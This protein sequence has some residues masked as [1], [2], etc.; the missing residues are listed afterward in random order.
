MGAS[1]SSFFRSDAKDLYFTR[2]SRP[3]KTGPTRVDVVGGM[4]E[5]MI[6]AN[7]TGCDGLAVTFIFEVQVRGD[8]APFRAFSSGYSAMTQICTLNCVS[9]YVGLLVPST[10]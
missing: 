1:S 6:I 9:H 2:F 10:D 4:F 3:N 7:A 5:L 8:R